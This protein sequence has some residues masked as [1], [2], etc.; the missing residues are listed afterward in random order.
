MMFYTLFVPQIC[1]TRY[2]FCKENQWTSIWSYSCRHWIIYSS[3][4][5]SIKPW[6][7][8]FEGHFI[9]VTAFVSDNTSYMLKTYK[10]TL[11]GL[12]PNAV[13]NRETDYDQILSKFKR[14]IFHLTSSIFSLFYKHVQT[15]S[16]LW[17]VLLNHFCA[18]NL[19]IKKKNL[20]PI[21]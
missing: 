6:L 14:I 13:N 20:L 16:V 3:V 21:A 12:M 8:N 19:K 18:D 1:F 9:N 7:L 11:K 5:D 10:E 2:L 15:I 4:A 17:L